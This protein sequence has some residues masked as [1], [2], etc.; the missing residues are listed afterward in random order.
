LFIFY[1]IAA[2]A[3]VEALLELL[4]IDEWLGFGFLAS[5]L[6]LGMLGCKLVI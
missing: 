6:V 5:G 1:V 4:L 3:D 2:A